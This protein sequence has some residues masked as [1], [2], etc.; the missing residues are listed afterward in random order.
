MPSG[1][2]KTVIFKIN[3]YAQWL[4]EYGYNR[5]TYATPSGNI[6][7]GS[8]NINLHVQWVSHQKRLVAVSINASSGNINI[9]LE[10]YT[11]TS[12]G[13]L[14]TAEIEKH[15]HT[16]SGHINTVSINSTYMLSDNLNTCAINKYTNT[17]RGDDNRTAAT[18]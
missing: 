11:Y 3:F 17:L 8:R 15:I 12:S 2:I 6:N 13:Y 16:P 18:W 4:S 9:V 5:D 14:N 1:N 7:I 10:I